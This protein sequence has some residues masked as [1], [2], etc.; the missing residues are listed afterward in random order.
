MTI[1]GLFPA[2]VTPFTAD[3]AIDHDGLQRH[4]RDII[5]TDGVTG[6]TVLG[7]AGEITTLTPEERTA[8]VATARA[9]VPAGKLL[10]AG[11][12]GR[13]ADLVTVE[14]QASI[15]AG[16]DALLVLPPF[17]VRP[18]RH[19]V[20]NPDAVHGFFNTL[21]ERLATPM[22]VFH[23]PPSTGC[24]YSL[25]ALEAAAEVPYV[26]AV[27]ASTGDIT[28]YAE[29]YDRLQGRISVLAA[30]DSP[31]L[32]PMLIHGADGAVLGVSAVGSPIWA[33]LIALC[34]SGDFTT[35]A[36]VFKRRCLPLTTAIY[37]NQLQRTGIASFAAAKEALVMLGR[38]G[39]ATIRPPAIAPD[40]ARKKV[41][42]SALVAAGLLDER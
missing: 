9:V 24:S 30:A 8:V 3:G 38:I 19:L 37:D 11:V 15:D 10:V 31:L 20:N 26:Q 6:V 13:T 16:A 42:E 1:Q 12:E 41:I 18:L 36:D 17:D 39:D 40:V 28:R 27:K 33:Q 32:L 5:E 14:S 34:H 21:S 25:Q 2:A 35:A 7:H 4:V 22:I 23:Y 29:L